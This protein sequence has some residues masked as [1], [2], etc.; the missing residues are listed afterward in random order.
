[1]GY[2]DLLVEGC[3]RGREGGRGVAVHQH[4]V[5]RLGLEQRLQALQH[6][7][8]DV[9]ERLRT[10]H[11]IQV[12]VDGQTEGLDHLVEHLPM[13]AGE[14]GDDAEVLAAVS[15]AEADEQRARHG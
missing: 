1:M 11:E 9:G 4:H 14:A 12:V 5:G 7:R 6:G 15:S 3:Q 10:T 2:G 8:R 13:L